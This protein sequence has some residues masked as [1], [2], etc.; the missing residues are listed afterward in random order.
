MLKSRRN[1]FNRTLSTQ[2]SNHLHRSL[3]VWQDAAL[4]RFFGVDDRAVGIDDEERSYGHSAFFVEDAILSADFAVWPEIRENQR[5][6]RDFVLFVV[7]S[8]P[9]KLH[10][11][12]VATDFEQFGSGVVCLFTDP[13]EDPE[14]PSST[15]CERRRM[16]RQNHSSTGFEQIVQAH[17][18]RRVRGKREVW[19]FLVFGE[20]CHPDTSMFGNFELSACDFVGKFVNPEYAVCP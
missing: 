9:C 19:C 2:L 6:F 1:R 20:Y 3:D 16:E 15:A 10:R 8:Y 7:G 4:S 13:T 11:Y 17:L 5:R 12:R 18:F 14:L